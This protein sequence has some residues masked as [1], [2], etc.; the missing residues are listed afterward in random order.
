MSDY[1]DMSAYYDLIMTSGYYDYGAIADALVR[2]P[3]VRS[4]LEIGAGTG[5]VLEQL[6]IRRPDLII[7]GVDLTQ[8]MLDIA[9]DRLA[10]YPQATMHLQ[11]V[12]TL[13]TDRTYDLAFSYGGVWYFVPEKEGP[14][15]AEGIAGLAAYRLVS[16]IRDEKD[17]QRG[18]ERLAAH[19]PSGATLLL[20]V[21]SP[22]RDYSRPVRNGMEYSQRITEIPDGFRKQ[23]GLADDGRPVMSQTLEYRTY[24]F[25]CGLELMSSCGLDLRGPVPAGGP[26]PAAPIFLEFGKR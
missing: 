7:D 15:D 12:V 25:D 26:E 6:A 5:L 10:A 4:V 3:G 16:H 2:V 21:Q 9:V 18:F 23:Y 1:T 24:S 20:G 8:A 17:N 19:L 22:H 13:A 14:P 11:N